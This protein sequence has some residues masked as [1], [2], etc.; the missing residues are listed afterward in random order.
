MGH[1]REEHDG[2]HVGKTRRR[3]VRCGA[4]HWGVF[5]CVECR[6]LQAPTTACVECG[7]SMVGP[8]ELVRELLGYRDVKIARG[9][10]W[11]FLTALLA[12][13]S[14]AFPM[15]LPVAFGGAIVAAIDKLT[16]RRRVIRGVALPPV[17]IARGAVTRIGTARRLRGT[18]T[19]I[20]DEAPV[21]VE[22][23]TICDREGDVLLRRS[24]S[25]PF[26]IDGDDGPVLVV[27]PVRFG[28]VEAGGRVKTGDVRLRRMGVPDD[29]ALSGR[30]RSARVAE[31]GRFA[32]TGVV[33]DEAVAELAFHRDGGGVPVMRG[34]VGAPVLVDAI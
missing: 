12:G 32:V 20:V 18:V 4:L 28:K 27:G 8:M 1:H 17:E 30:L 5:C 29:L 15:L 31:V 16:S 14:I 25:A 13:S 3:R 24:A 9:R 22:Q 21:L 26:L 19:S 10:D 6:L 2:V 34:A 7:T 11:A 23:A 33:E